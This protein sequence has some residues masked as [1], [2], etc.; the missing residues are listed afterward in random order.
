MFVVA[1]VVLICW[2]VF[3][4]LWKFSSKILL[5]FFFWAFELELFSFFCSYYSQVSSFHGVPNCVDF[6]YHEFFQIFAVNLANVLICSVVSSMPEFL[7]SV[8]C[9]LLMMLMFVVHVLFSMFFIS[10]M[11]QFVFSLLLLF[12]FLGPSLFDYI[13]LYFF[14]F[15]CFLL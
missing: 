8:S 10:R 2:W 11:T 13:F 3:F 14:I 6:C 5:N 9:I 4:R 15:I 7:F 12:P 1:V